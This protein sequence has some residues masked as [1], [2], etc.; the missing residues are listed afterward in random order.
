MEWGFD[1]KKPS[2]KDGGVLYWK[3]SCFLRVSGELPW[4][5]QAAFPWTFYTKRLSHCSFA[6][7]AEHRKIS[8]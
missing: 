5:Y 4:M 1:G 3:E 8:A 2:P 7:S 6:S